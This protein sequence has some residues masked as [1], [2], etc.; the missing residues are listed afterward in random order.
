MRF[1][2]P[3]WVRGVICALAVSSAAPVNA[4]TINVPAGGDLQQAINTAQPGDVIALAPG[5]VYVGNFVLP[6]KGALTDYITIRTATP[7]ASLPPA[8]VRITPAYAGVLAKIKSSN[9]MSALRTQA[10]ANY[11]ALMFLEFQANVGGYGD[12]IA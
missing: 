12:V 4:A 3:A 8:N 7:D 2:F 6:N 9:N 1:G 5:A 11:Y 10:G